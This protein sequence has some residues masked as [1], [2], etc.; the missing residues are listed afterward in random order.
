MGQRVAD[1]TMHK[2]KEQ[3]TGNGDWDVSPAEVL[4]WPQVLGRGLEIRS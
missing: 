3:H 1:L 2:V 4:I